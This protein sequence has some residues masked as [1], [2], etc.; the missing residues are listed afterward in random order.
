MPWKNLIYPVTGLFQHCSYESYY[1]YDSE[2]RVKW[3]SRYFKRCQCGMLSLDLRLLVAL[4]GGNDA[5]L[6][7]TNSCWV[8]TFFELA[9]LLSKIAQAWH[10]TLDTMY[11][12]TDLTN[13]YHLSYTY[14]IHMFRATCTLCTVHVAYVSCNMVLYKNLWWSFNKPIT[15]IQITFQCLQF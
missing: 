12:I 1:L 13:Y 2:V 4:V 8:G 7:M 5:K 3:R 6:P 9:I 14:Y 10:L 15:K 11:L